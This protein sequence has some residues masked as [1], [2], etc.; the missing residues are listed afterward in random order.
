MVA[1][2]V[3]VVLAAAVAAA[4]AAGMEVARSAAGVE[5]AVDGRRDP[6]RLTPPQLLTEET[7]PADDVR[8]LGG[9]SF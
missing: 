1:V 9:T 6:W 3:L 5:D 8:G 7:P 4:T 2:F